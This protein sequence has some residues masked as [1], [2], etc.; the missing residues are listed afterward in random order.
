MLLTV[1][2][3][4]GIA[5]I[6]PYRDTGAGAVEQGG[7]GRPLRDILRSP[8]VILAVCSAALGYGVMSLLMTATP[9][10]MHTHAGH[11]LESTKFVIQSHI[12]AMYLPSLVYAA[13]CRRLG[14]V[15]MLWL[16]IAAYLVCLAIALADTAFL[17]Y[18]AAL[19]LLGLGWNFLFLS[20]TNL[21][22]RGYPPVERFRVQSANEFLVFSVQALA[23]LSSGWFLYHIGWRGLV[24][25]CL[26]L[27]AG[28]VL[29]FS[30][31][32]R[33]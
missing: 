12:A 13:L 10:S 29:V 28:F 24:V 5:L 27:L 6:S 21:L 14:F 16:G 25:V 23:S 11:S 32:G 2:Y 20:G 9:I 30:V 4:A 19:I 15:G 8:I 18:W 7:E 1:S 22:P 31:C 3:L 26:P 17:N 33:I